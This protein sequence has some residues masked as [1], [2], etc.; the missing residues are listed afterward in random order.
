MAEFAEPAPRVVER[1]RTPARRG[2]LAEVGAVG[3]DLPLLRVPVLLMVTTS[4]K[5][6]VVALQSPPAWIFSPTLANYTE[7]L[8]ED[9]VGFALVN[10][11][12]AVSTTA[13]S[14][15]LAA[16]P[17]TRSPAS[18][19]AASATSG[20]GSSPIASSRR[21]SSPSRSS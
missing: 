8:F 12:I 4:L 9:R 18:S 21:L 16:R 2:L 15:D 7:V 5:T 11:L 3:A 20:S 17:P 10:S 19:S 1:R 13:L 14:I 6:Q